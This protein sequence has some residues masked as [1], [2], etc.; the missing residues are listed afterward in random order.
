MAKTHRSNEPLKRHHWKS[1]R[2][3]RRA[4]IAHAM[5]LL[6]SGTEDDDVLEQTEALLEAKPSELAFHRPDAWTRSSSGRRTFD[7]EGG[8][9]ITAWNTADK[10]RLRWKL[11]R[12]DIPEHRAEELKDRLNIH[13]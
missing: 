4:R 5:D 12:G 1:A 10:S 8:R 7:A 11:Q 2:T 13:D 3:E 6:H 9:G